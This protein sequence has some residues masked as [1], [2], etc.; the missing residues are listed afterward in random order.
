MQAG[1]IPEATEAFARAIRIHEEL[2]STLRE[3]GSLRLDLARAHLGT[4]YQFR[5]CESPRAIP[6]FEWAAGL[7]RELIAEDPDCW[8]SAGSSP[9]RWTALPCGST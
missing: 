6:L 1:K 7:Y 2:R 8:H 4:V 9:T 5:A 3:D